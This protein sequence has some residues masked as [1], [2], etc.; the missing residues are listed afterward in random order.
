MIL[1]APR[2]ASVLVE[3]ALAIEALKARSVDVLK[4][5]VDLQFV[6]APKFPEVVP[7]QVFARA[8]SVHRANAARAKKTVQKICPE[9]KDREFF[10]FLEVGILRYLL[11]KGERKRSFITPL[12]KAGVHEGFM[13]SK[14]FRGEVFFCQ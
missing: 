10:I 12:N 2:N 4:A 6:E 1:F 9:E 13:G 3:L 14:E 7:C 11:G 5:G 8:G